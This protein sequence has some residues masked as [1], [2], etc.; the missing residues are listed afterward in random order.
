MAILNSSNYPAIRAA[1]DTSL[2]SDMLPDS[3]L[4]LDIYSGAADAW[5][6]DRDASAESRTG[7]DGDRIKR[8]AV[9][10]CAALL[11]PAVPSLVE[12]KD[13]RLSYKRAAVDWQARAR[14]LKAMADEEVSTVISTT[15]RPTFFAVAAG[16]RGK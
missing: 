7:S 2:D 11:A 15:V 3:I 4:D 13:E 16:T 6:I 12:A 8:A 14:E 5:V 1:L 10:Y 9:Y